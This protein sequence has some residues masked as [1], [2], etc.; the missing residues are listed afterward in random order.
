MMSKA[1]SLSK[2]FR[3]PDEESAAHGDKRALTPM[4]TL[5]LDKTAFT[6]VSLHDADVADKAYWAAQSPRFRLEALEF[7]RQV[8][9]G[10][11]PI[12]ARLERVLEVVERPSS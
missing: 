2:G 6:V 7:M 3:M 12:T 1:T 5:R 10:Y 4:E 11:D 8:A 9:Y